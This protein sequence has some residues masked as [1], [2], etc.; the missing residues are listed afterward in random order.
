MLLQAWNSYFKLIK[1]EAFGHAHRKCS[2]MHN[3]QLL[4]ILEKEKVSIN[5]KESIFVH[6]LNI[7]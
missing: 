5:G 3:I 1:E 6:I 7:Q 4:I 2:Q